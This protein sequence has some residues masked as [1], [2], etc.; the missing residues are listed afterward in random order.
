M[1]EK[2]FWVK[3]ALLLLILE[4][5]YIIY[6]VHLKRYH[7]LKVFIILVSCEEKL[8]DTITE[9]YVEGTGVHDT[10]DLFS[11]ELHGMVILTSSLLM[12]VCFSR[13]FIN[14]LQSNDNDFA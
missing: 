3:Y 12:D 6:S 7:F 1:V 13:L 8:Y 2:C 10:Q 9:D 11:C 5:L 4:L 14:S